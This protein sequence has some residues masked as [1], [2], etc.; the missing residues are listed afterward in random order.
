M[1]SSIRLSAFVPSSVLQCVAI[2]CSGVCSS[3]LFLT[4][5]CS[6]KKPISFYQKNTILLTYCYSFSDHIQEIQR[7]VGHFGSWVV[8][9]DQKLW[10][11]SN[12][13]NSFQIISEK[14]NQ[15]LV[16]LGVESSDDWSMKAHKTTR[17]IQRPVPLDS[18]IRA[19]DVSVESSVLENRARLLLAVLVPCRFGN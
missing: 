2:C 12:I 3:L 7:K 8:S 15:K 1:Q 5:Y 17:D 14:Y 10:L 11:Y 6:H 18:N 16:I 19:L 4:V 13:A 9:F